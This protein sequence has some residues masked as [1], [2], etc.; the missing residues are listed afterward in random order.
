MNV[1]S[2]FLFPLFIGLVLK[3]FGLI[4]Y[5]MVILCALVGVFVDIDHYI[6]NIIHAKTNRYSLINAWN[7]AMK[8]HRFQQ[9]SF[10]HHIEGFILLSTF[11]AVMVF[12]DL[13]WAVIV[14]V[15][16]YSHM[17]LDYIPLNQN[18]YMR[19]H[20]SKIFFSET[21]GELN[22]DILIIILIAITMIA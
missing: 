2:H 5:E 8:Y 15:G 3:K 16:Y 19:W 17:I 10:I 20:I 12:V 18:K 9:R 7:N 21:Q 4:S 11:I 22:L 13:N 1:P 6:E 14:A